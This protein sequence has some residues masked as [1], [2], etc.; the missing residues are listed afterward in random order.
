MVHYTG[1]LDVKFFALINNN[2]DRVSGLLGDCLVDIFNHPTVAKYIP[3]KV[4]YSH[5]KFYRLKRPVLVRDDDTDDEDG[6][7]DRP[8]HNMKQACLDETNR[9][10]IK[11]LT[12]KVHQLAKQISDDHIYLV[13]DFPDREYHHFSGSEYLMLLTSS[14][15]QHFSRQRRH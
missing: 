10:P 4:S 13:I 14:V 9:A 15:S 12:T 7:Q 6:G 3:A 2:V 1:Q 8:P 11:P 5:C